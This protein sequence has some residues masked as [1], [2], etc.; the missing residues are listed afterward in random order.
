MLEKIRMAQC[1]ITES[2]QIQESFSK[3]WKSS[4]VALC[5]LVRQGLE[6]SSSE[7]CTSENV[8]TYPMSQWRAIILFI[9]QSLRDN[10]EFSFSCIH[11][12]H[13][14][15]ISPC[16][17]PLVATCLSLV[18]PDCLHTLSL[19]EL[20]SFA[21]DILFHVS[22][23]P[24]LYR[25]ILGIFI[26][27]QKILKESFDLS[28][29]L[30]QKEKGL[31]Q[32]LIPTFV[33]HT[34][35]PIINVSMKNHRYRMHALVNFRECVLE[36]LEFEHHRASIKNRL[37]RLSSFYSNNPRND[38]TGLLQGRNDENAQ[39]LP[40]HPTVHLWDVVPYLIQFLQISY[41]C[42]CTVMKRE[43]ISF[44]F[45][46][47]ILDIKKGDAELH[48]AKC[49]S[50]VA[51]IPLGFEETK[52]VIYLLSVTP[53][54]ASSSK[55]DSLSIE[56]CCEM[57][58]NLTQ[59]LSYLLE[60]LSESCFSLI[61]EAIS[62]IVGILGVMR[63]INFVVN[64]ILIRMNNEA[65]MNELLRNDGYLWIKELLLHSCIIPR[66]L[67]LLLHLF[68]K[69]DA[70]ESQEFVSF[71]TSVYQI[72]NGF[73]Q[74]LL[75]C[76]SVNQSLLCIKSVDGAI[77][78]QIQENASSGAILKSRIHLVQIF[79]QQSML[80]LYALFRGIVESQSL[81]ICQNMLLDVM[82]KTISNIFD[83]LQSCGAVQNGQDISEWITEIFC[84][85]LLEEWYECCTNEVLKARFSFGAYIEMRNLLKRI[86]SSEHHENI[87]GL[88]KIQKPL[89]QSWFMNMCSVLDVLLDEIEKSSK[90]LNLSF[91]NCG[92]SSD[93]QFFVQTPDQIELEKLSLLDE[94]RSISHKDRTEF[95]KFIDKAEFYAPQVAIRLLA[96]MSG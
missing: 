16:D 90:I 21:T 78:E 8:Q 54:S 62:T 48:E 91:P 28:Q 45:D 76:F 39:I 84:K 74:L 23:Y 25:L 6:H 87:G 41:R 73:E 50:L 70:I 5:W 79:K 42:G 94:W 95:T 29:T 20:H 31:H 66:Q 55:L 11:Q 77:L 12:S 30:H 46:S 58:R 83:V 59:M 57:V 93:Q 10:L 17:V 49:S 47:N 85:K 89:F 22:N 43:Y 24:I 2:S 4:I 88:I 75:N 27:S 61:T 9:F 69:T 96:Q 60:M 15:D 38:E 67:V 7:S 86:S 33:R 92:L 18:Y 44:F 63:V 52:R 26:P 19:S 34:L 13:T 65:H 53:T 3:S 32:L 72:I 64:S 71:E 36:Y 35:M 80:V 82:Q 1:R 56:K 40:Q 68:R 14:K 81:S 37:Q 51:Q